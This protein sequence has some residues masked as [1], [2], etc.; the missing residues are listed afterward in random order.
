MVSFVGSGAYIWNTSS[1]E[2]VE[3]LTPD[4]YGEIVY[5]Q[6]TLDG[7]FLVTADRA[8]TMTLRGPET[9]LALGPVLTG[10]SSGIGV[11][12]ASVS[13]SRDGTRM[14]STSGAEELFLWD[15]DKRCFTERGSC[16]HLAGVD[17]G[18]TFQAPPRPRPS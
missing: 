16:G 11:W 18:G 4:E 2:L 7:R 17:V 3:H 12:P 10:H 8:R 1:W 9:H 6:Y 14:A 13:V 5:A 15:M